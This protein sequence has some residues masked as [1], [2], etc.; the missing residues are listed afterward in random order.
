[1]AGFRSSSPRMSLG[2]FVLGAGHHIAAWR[3]PGAPHGAATDFAHYQRIARIAED[4]KFDM[5]FFADSASIR[6]WGLSPI[7][8]DERSVRLEPITLLS[9]LSVTTER[10]GLVA[11]ASTTYN[12]PFNIARR[13]ASL[14]LLSGG[15]AGW[16]LV[17]SSNAQDGPNFAQ[18]SHPPHAERYARAEEFWQV[19]K[20]LWH[21]WQGDDAFPIDKSAGI[22]FR[23]E[24][25]RP[26]DHKG[27]HFS[28]RGPLGVP[29][30]P[31]GHPVVVQA[32]ASEAGRETAARSAEVVFAAHQSFDEAF[33]F[34][35]D[36]KGRLARYGRAPDSLR[37]LPG[38]SP[39][40]GRTRAEAQ[41]AFDAL[42]ELVST[43]SGLKL[44]A[45]FTGGLDLRAYDPDGPLPDLPP[46][47]NAIGRQKLLVDLARRE[48]LTIR[49][50]W[51]HIAGARGHWQI[52]GTAGDIADQLEHHFRGG[53]ADGFNIMPP[54]LPR[55]L[56]TIT[57]L[58][59]PELRRRGLFREDYDG[60][61]LRDHLGLPR[62]A[63]PAFPNVA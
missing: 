44:L 18:G 20:G 57:G 34:Y 60:S 15:R 3:L 42:Q 54:A 10:I 47:T 56:E 49:Q 45:P 26:L 37:I 12:E 17:T 9:A 62:P 58:L 51:L 29:P 31:Q 59:L 53:A 4:A 19:V 25:L 11:T 2:L 6:D 55:S 46:T 24:A 43:E 23:P 35:Q 14:D 48:N 32:G 33:T 38:V 22:L 50:L 16:N 28:V 61:T 7:D 41:A 52:V 39:V 1:M 5:I 27:P 30:S 40:V 36:V 63:L 13:F 8:G 21:S